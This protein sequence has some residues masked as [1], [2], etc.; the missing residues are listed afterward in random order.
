MPRR[1]GTQ[2]SFTT[3]SEDLDL[4]G[5]LAL[6]SHRVQN[7]RDKTQALNEQ[8]ARIGLKFNATNTT[9]LSIYTKR[10]DGVFI[11]R[12]QVE[13]VDDFTYLGRIVHKK[14]GSD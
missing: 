2:W 11:E 12:E 4:A 10:S 5:D 7:I 9:M 14:G 1:R 3:S 8:G 13:Q 6:L